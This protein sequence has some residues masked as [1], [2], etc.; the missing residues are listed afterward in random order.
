M[1]LYVPNEVLPI[2]PTYTT[3]VKDGVKYKAYFETDWHQVMTEDGVPLCELLQSMPS[4]SS[5][6]FY[7][8]CG[9][10]KSGPNSSAMEQLY[11]LTN[12]KNGDV[13]LV[14]TDIVA[15]GVKVCESYVW[16]GNEAGWVYCGTTNR[17]ASFNRD[18]PDVI[19]LFPDELGEPD[20]VLVVS[21][22]GKSITWG[23]VSTEA[24]NEDPKAHQDIRQT[25]DLK[26]DRLVIFNDIL[27][28]GDWVYNGE[29]PCFEY[30]YRSDML[31]PGAY[32]EITP[33]VDNRKEVENVTEAA[34]SPVYRIQSGAN[35]APYAILR[36]KRVPD[37]D[38][39]ICVKCFG[40]YIEK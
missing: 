4:Y 3:V 32:F 30:I 39:E 36:A 37:E 22:D 20:Q 14:E 25:L 1:P 9:L 8:Y 18:L 11:A 21:K 26:M 24:H 29:Y 15:D 10:F 34:I 13:Y 16:L 5:N 17:K 27:S 38:I 6:N 12:Q 33:V 2:Y 40:T 28:S 35:R 19:K 7:K 23:G 31:P